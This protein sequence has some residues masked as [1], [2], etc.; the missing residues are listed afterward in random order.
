M[1]IS[2]LEAFAESPYVRQ[3]SNHRPNISFDLF[4]VIHDILSFLLSLPGGRDF[5]SNPYSSRNQYQRN[6]QNDNID[7]HFFASFSRSV[8]IVLTLQ[9]GLIRPEAFHEKSLVVA[10][11]VGRPWVDWY[12]GVVCSL[13][14]PL[15]MILRSES[16][17]RDR[18][19]GT[20]CWHL[21]PTLPRARDLERPSSSKSR[22]TKQAYQEIRAIQD[23]WLYEVL[24][25][26]R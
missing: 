1:T 11:N 16:C 7:Y 13:F 21:P 6:N 14:V 26:C 19:W 4:C 5:D 24:R 23:R 22:S 3:S 18:A 17:S 15:D 2:I 10:S 20:E 25:S 9:D 8:V 12:V